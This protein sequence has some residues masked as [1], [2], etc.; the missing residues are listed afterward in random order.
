MEEPEEYEKND[1]QKLLC[2]LHRSLYGLKQAPWQWNQ[3]IDTFFCE[4][5]EM[6]KNSA[7]LCM[8]VLHSSSYI[9]LIVLYVHD[10]PIASDSKELIT[11]T[12]RELSVKLRLKDLGM[13]KR[14]CAWTSNGARTNRFFLKSSTHS[15]S[16]SVLEFKMWKLRELQ[17]IQTRD[18]WRD[19][20]S[21][22]R[23]NW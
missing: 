19:A 4:K 8:Y 6:S 12:K 7:N 10:P 17:W 9:F 2:K 13:F 18:Q 23:S 15:G 20:S 21:K 14:F 11:N 3:E 22:Q 16:W 1:K 5:L